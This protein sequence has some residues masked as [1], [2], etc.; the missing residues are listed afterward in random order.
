MTKEEFI[1]NQKRRIAE[2]ALQQVKLITAEAQDIIKDLAKQRKK[3]FGKRKR[4]PKP[5]PN[6][7]MLAK[8]FS[9]AMHVRQLEIQKHIIA[10]Q[11]YPPKFPPGG[12]IAVIKQTGPDFVVHGKIPMHIPDFPITFI[13]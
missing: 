5:K 13:P 8:V 11:P 12:Q 3:A 2:I 10:S 1:T 9:T 7:R 4:K 6:Y